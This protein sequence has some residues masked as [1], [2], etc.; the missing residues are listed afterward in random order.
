MFCAGRARRRFCTALLTLLAA[1]PAPG[2]GAAAER[3]L[4][5]E[6][7]ISGT[8]EEV[9]RAWTTS[10]GIASFFAPQSEIEVRVGGK[11]EL[12]IAADSPPGRR[13]TEGCHL[14]AYVPY[15]MLAFEWNAPPSIPSL[16]DANAH[17]QVVLRFDEAGAGR[18]R[19]RFAQLGWGEGEDWEKCY[20]Y[21][22]RAW[23]NVLANLKAV[24][25]RNGGPAE[26]GSAPAEGSAGTEAAAAA[27]SAADRSWIDGAV[28][29]IAVEGA[30]REQSF[31]VVVPASVPRIWHAL[32]TAEGLGQ[33]I[34]PEAEVELTP[35]GTYRIFK[36]SNTAVQ[37]F[38]PG[39]MLAV[40]GSAPLEFPNV[41]MGGTWGVMEMEPFGE[42]G[43]RLRM[44][45]YGWRDGDEWDRAYEYFL[46]NN[47]IFLNLL[48]Q[49]FVDGPLTWSQETPEAPKKF[50]RQPLETPEQVAATEVRGDWVIGKDHVAVIQSSLEDVW[51]AV[52]TRTGL[53]RWADPAA[54]VEVVP[55][56]RFRCRFS[57]E[58]ASG[59]DQWTSTRVLSVAPKRMLSLAVQP[60]SSAGSDAQEDAK[61]VDTW[62]VWR[63]EP[64]GPDQV[65][66]R[67]LCVAVKR[68]GRQD[69][70][71]TRLDQQ[72]AAAVEA[73]RACVVQ[74]RG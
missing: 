16:R 26:N 60:L 8:L 9:W 47:A 62:I 20:A 27:G 30:S 69:L 40:T 43:T 54:E 39:E 45:V 15:D 46:K 57:R 74:S 73:L 17:T 34:A 2:D 6:V 21:F 13:G 65:Q 71:L 48:R 67:C 7:T 35:G 3:V 18:V 11:Y 52:T 56:G 19:V 10:E 1:T 49:R 61:K 51:A 29:V 70:A 12:Y 38:V 59:K 42:E 44:S 25:E 36:G 58:D 32:A 55:G 72:L 50:T 41:R 5:K 28:N 4:R 53:S 68:G 31:E 14:L 64:V 37:A 22:D 23:T 66:V 33:F 63:F 24:L